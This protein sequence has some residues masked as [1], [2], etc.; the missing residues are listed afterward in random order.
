MFLSL[1]YFLL[2]S[3]TS[4]RLPRPNYRRL[5]ASSNGDTAVT[6]MYYFFTA[7]IRTFR[8]FMF[9]FLLRTAHIPGY[10]LVRFFKN[11]YRLLV[12]NYRRFGLTL[13]SLFYIVR[14][15]GV[16]LARFRS[17]PTLFRKSCRSG[18]R[19]F[20][21]K[22]RLVYSRTQKKT[23]LRFSK[24]TLIIPR[25][26]PTTPM[27]WRTSNFNTRSGFMAQNTLPFLFNN[28]RS[29][30]SN[31]L[32]TS[33][34]SEFRLKVT[35]FLRIDFK[36]T[37]IRY[38][39]KPLF[40]RRSWLLGNRFLWS[41]RHKFFSFNAFGFSSI[42]YLSNRLNTLVS[43]S[44]DARSYRKSFLFKTRLRRIT[45]LWVSKVTQRT[46]TPSRR[47][48]NTLYPSK[49][50][51][52]QHRLTLLILRYYRFRV[53]EFINLFEFSLLNVL[54]RTRFFII[55]SVAVDFILRGWVCINGYVSKNLNDLLSFFDVLYLTPSL[56]WIFFYRWH[57][58]SVRELMGRFY[59]YLRKWR[60]R[61]HRPYPKQS[62][63]RIPNWVR[64][65]LFYRE[66]VPIFFEIDFLTFS[67]IN[68]YN[69]LLTSQNYHYLSI[70]TFAPA[71]IRPLNWKSLT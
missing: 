1:L 6:G 29:G 9:F 42:N 38:N 59:Y 62:S 33:W 7:R 69:P 22:R 70:N 15:L 36:R 19:V 45:T 60:E 40:L 16:F 30:F 58:L 47:E 21:L 44:P 27:L 61:S 51:R 43:Q 17:L 25:R 28:S 2:L 65:K 11:R 35:R 54:L 37:V 10:R 57:L 4:L 63:Y 48:F 71:T 34:L 24:P 56:I 55:R 66:A 31:I 5:V 3:C 12:F 23:Q 8:S 41:T 26:A 53:L 14:P 18:G 39:L 64:K 32:L 50:L 67:C 20:F 13:L 68:L 52:Y 49:Q 46:L